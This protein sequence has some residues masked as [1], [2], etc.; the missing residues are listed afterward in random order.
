M[1]WCLLLQIGLAAAL[2]V[3][4][5]SLLRAAETAT[6]AALRADLQAGSLQP[7]LSRQTLVRLPK[8]MLDKGLTEIHF[9]SFAVTGF[10]ENAERFAARL[11]LHLIE[12]D[13]AG[14]PS[15]VAFIRVAGTPG[16]N[17]T[18][19]QF[20]DYAT[21][22]DLVSL[23]SRKDWLSGERG[24]AFISTLSD[25]PGSSSL[26]ELA[27]GQPAVLALWLA[28]CS[29][30]PCESVALKAQVATAQP[31]LWQLRR[32]FA[33]GDRGA[34]NAQLATLRSALGDDPWLW[35]VTGIYARH[36][37]RCRWVT[38]TLQEAWERQ[39]NNR[40]LSDSTLQC[41]LATLGEGKGGLD[42]Q[43]TEFLQRLSQEIGPGNLSE[44]IDRY[45]RQ[46]PRMRPE[47]LSPWMT[48]SPGE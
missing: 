22:L 26:A 28:Q 2:C 46:H 32:A 7:L 4:P 1:R 35:Y 43:G 38:Q 48:R 45:Y 14:S 37:Q 9:Q 5:V 20:Y 8:S 36:H 41:T 6:L 25:D 19:D 18:V 16:P 13:D 33:E 11:R 34:V 31:A 15:G 29:G 12:N 3:Q 21:G 10:N 27:E 23:H 24:A 47:A 44:A 39:P 30:H 40:A 17:Y 42:T